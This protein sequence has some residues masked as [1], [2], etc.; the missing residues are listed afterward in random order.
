MAN[1]QKIE[2]TLTAFGVEQDKDFFE[3]GS[4]ALADYNIAQGQFT[5]SNLPGTFTVIDNE[6]WILF[7]TDINNE[8]S[9]WSLTYRSG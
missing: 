2:F 1:A 3:Y 8:L 5:G 6:A 7:T 4:G 9:G